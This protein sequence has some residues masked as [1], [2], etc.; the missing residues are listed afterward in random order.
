MG[1]AVK[2][3][4]AAAAGQ[5]EVTQDGAGVAPGVGF[6][7]EQ[8]LDVDAQLGG[9]CRVKALVDVQ[10]DD[11]PF[12]LGLGDQVESH[13]GSLG[14]GNTEQFAHLATGHTANAQRLIQLGKAGRQVGNGLWSR[15]KRPQGE[16]SV[17]GLNGLD[18]HLQALS[19]VVVAHAHRFPSVW[20]PIGWGEFGQRTHVWESIVA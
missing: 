16:V 6:D 1:R 5:D 10:V 13:R 11:R 4:Q 17:A 8:R 2:Q 7:R 3:Q 20:P 9:R 15:G 14:G 19:F 12:G 18:G